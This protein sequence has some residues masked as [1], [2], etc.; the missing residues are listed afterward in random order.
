LRAKL[1]STGRVDVEG[2]SGEITL[3]VSAP[4]GVSTEIC[5]RTANN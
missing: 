5:S 2:V 1:T 3:R 4:G